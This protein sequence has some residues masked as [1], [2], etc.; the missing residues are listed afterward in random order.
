MTDAGKRIVAWKWLRL[1]LDD[2]RIDGLCPICGVQIHV[3]INKIT[4]NGHLIG[5]CGDAFT[6]A[7]WEAYCPPYDI[8]CVLTAEE[9]FIESYTDVSIE[10]LEF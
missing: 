3:M 8:G 4:D 2:G 7:Q 10:D 6:I 5:S 1:Y 9:S